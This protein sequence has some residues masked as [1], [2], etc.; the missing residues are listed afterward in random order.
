MICSDKTGTLT[1]NVMTVVQGCIAGQEFTESG[2]DNPINADA[3]QLFHLSSK[4]NSTAT[5]KVMPDQTSKFVGNATE[6]AML[7]FS[8]QL[9]G[10]NAEFDSAGANRIDFLPFNSASKSASCLVRADNG[11]FIHFATGASE[12]IVSKCSLALGKKGMNEEKI[13]GKEWDNRVQLMAKSG[14]RTVGLCYRKLSQKEAH[15]GLEALKVEKM[16]M[17]GVLG[18][19]DPVRKEVPAA[20]QTC[21][22]AGITVRMVTGD[23]ID[24]ARFIAR[25]CH[26]LEGEPSEN[27]ALEGPVFAKMSDDQIKALVD[28]K[29]GGKLRVLARSSP[30]DKLRLVKILKELDEVVAVTGDGT[31]DAPALKEANVGLAMNIAGTEVA[32]EASDIVIIDDNFRSIVSAVKWGRSV[33]DNIRKFIQFQLTIN[34][35]ALILAF[36]SAVWCAIAPPKETEFTKASF[37]T[38]K[39]TPLNAIQLLWVNL[40]MDAMGALALA[41]EEPEDALLLRKPVGKS[42]GLISAN[43]WR[44]IA[45]QGLYQ[46]FVLFGILFS[47]EVLFDATGYT[48]NKGEAYSQSRPHY[49]VIFNA[50]VWCQIFNEFNSRRLDNEPS[51]FRGVLKSKIFLFIIVCTVVTQYLFVEYGGEYTKTVPLTQRDWLVTVL[52]GSISIPIGF[53][54][55]LIAGAASSAPAKP[56][57]D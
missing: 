54:T 45:V 34:F 44:N 15:D 23:N 42:E 9:R 57:G 5:A 49:T 30:M 6:C 8:Q 53:F 11:D 22:T 28:P 40:I 27:E 51:A 13:N 50:F 20:V 17:L 52:I 7:K 3:L 39:C 4:F 14:L 25:E 33:F 31:N 36:F 18:V 47:P 55:R 26:I 38:E 1:Q 2:P 24:T 29:L 10:G 21:K 43:M 19:K 41:T 56:K 46:L 37:D 32:K 48:L 16:T 12:A 35:V